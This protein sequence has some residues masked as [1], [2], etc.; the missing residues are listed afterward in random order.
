MEYARYLLGCLRV[1]LSLLFSL[2]RIR[3]VFP[4]L[5]DDLSSWQ[6]QFLRLEFRIPSSCIGNSWCF[7]ILSFYY[8]TLLYPDIRR[9]YAGQ[10]GQSLFV[11]AQDY[12]RDIILYVMARQFKKQPKHRNVVF[13]IL[14]TQM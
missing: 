14:N 10:V 3:G 5:S 6:E 9:F 2:P 7:S 4:R 1:S 12:Y 11:R 13:C 8:N